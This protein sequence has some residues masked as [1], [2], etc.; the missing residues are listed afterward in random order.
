MTDA[1]DVF[2]RRNAFIGTSHAMVVLRY[3]HAVEAQ[4]PK[5]IHRPHPILQ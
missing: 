2:K 3:G 5:Y 1:C 4:V